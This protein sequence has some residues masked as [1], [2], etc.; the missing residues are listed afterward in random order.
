MKCAARLSATG[1]GRAAGAAAG[2]G[3]AAALVVRAGAYDEELVATAVRAPLRPTFP[4]QTQTVGDAG[5]GT[6]AAARGH[7]SGRTRAG[8]PSAPSPL[9]PPGGPRRA[10]RRAVRRRLDA[11]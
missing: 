2:R 7:R 4:F 9:S 3:R 11:R 8:P 6:A 1:R 5:W 10:P